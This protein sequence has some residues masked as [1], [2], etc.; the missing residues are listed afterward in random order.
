MN[1]NY[2]DLLSTTIIGVL[3]VAITNHL[4]CDDIEISSVTYLAAGYVVGYFVNALGSLLEKEYYKTIGGRPSDKLLSLVAGQNWTGYERIKFYEANAAI[5]R[6]RAELK[7]P[8]ASTEKMFGCAMKKVNGCT[9]SRV[10]TFNAQYAWS[11]TLL[12][13]VLIADLSYI[14]LF[15]IYAL[16]YDYRGY[17][18]IAIDVL[19]PIISF[20]SWNRFKEMGYYYAKEVLSEYLKQTQK[21]STSASS[22]NS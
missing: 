1:L 19:L 2:Y 11:R 8:S 6:L 10:P 3:I 17:W 5:T 4:L 7:D 16:C 22:H 18:P 12:T 15:P 13:T 14:I 21:E 9:S 20:L